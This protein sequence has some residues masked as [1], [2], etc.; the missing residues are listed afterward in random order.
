MA[1]NI[2]NSEV[3][4]LAN[5]VAILTGETK[6]EAVKRALEERRDRLA[7]QLTTEDKGT[8]L[9]RWLETEVWPRVPK[10]QLGRTLTREEE[11]EILGYGR[12]GI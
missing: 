12:D 9:R 10:D 4:R 7:Y 11:D 2:K 5:E 8:R 6:T 1:L 3:E